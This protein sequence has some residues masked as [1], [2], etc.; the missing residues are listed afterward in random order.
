MWGVKIKSVTNQL[1]VVQGLKRK[2][3]KTR[4]NGQYNRK[5]ERGVKR[6][7]WYGNIGKYEK[8]KDEECAFIFFLG[9]YTLLMS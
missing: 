1:M 8:A 2:E 7:V 6:F 5:E 4:V 3:K 9:I